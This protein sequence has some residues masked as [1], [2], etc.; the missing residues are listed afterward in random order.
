MLVCALGTVYGFNTEQNVRKILIINLVLRIKVMGTENRC[1]WCDDTWG[2]IKFN[3]NL[4]L[5]S[6]LE[7]KTYENCSCL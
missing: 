7:Q 3:F 6:C 5:K 2:A 1:L 4:K